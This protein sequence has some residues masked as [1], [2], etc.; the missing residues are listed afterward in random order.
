MK[1]FLPV[2]KFIVLTFLVSWMLGFFGALILTA[3]LNMI[4]IFRSE[5]PSLLAKF[6]PS[7]AGLMMIGHMYGK[8]GFKQLIRHSNVLNISAFYLLAA[9]LFPF[10]I[11]VIAVEITGSIQNFDFKFNLENG[12]YI[13]TSVILTH[14]FFGGG[15]GEEFGWRA[16][17]LPELIQRLNPILTTL[18]TAFFWTI[19]HVPAF[20]FTYGKE[21]PFLPFVFLVF[22]LSFIFTWLYF[23]TNQNILI[24]A[25]FHACINASASLVD[26]SFYEDTVV[27]YWVFASILVFFGFILVIIS[28]GR[29]GYDEN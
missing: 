19:W 13:Y 29:L 7:V 12:I 4:G 18:V 3:I 16:F 6:G 2:I 11:T 9:I 15:F 24:S 17:M 20:L 21:D 22:G 27:F 26:F 28:R 25:V 14:L 23:K 10:I 5:A 8:N 1:P